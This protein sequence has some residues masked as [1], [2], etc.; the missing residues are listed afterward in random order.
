MRSQA[1][2]YSVGVMVTGLDKHSEH[3]LARPRGDLRSITVHWDDVTE[4]CTDAIIA[5][6]ARAGVVLID[7]TAEAPAYP[8]DALALYAAV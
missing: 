1:R 3:P 6:Q 2:L 8:T 5:E 4:L 7:I